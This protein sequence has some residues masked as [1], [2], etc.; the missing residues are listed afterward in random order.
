[1][2]IYSINNKLNQ[3]QQNQAAAQAKPEKPAPPAPQTPPE[4]A[5]F[6]AKLGLS[7]TNSKEGDMA[8]I[9]AKLAE[10]EATAKT[11]SQKQ[12]LENLKRELGNV[13]GSIQPPQGPPPP[14]AADFTGADQ[15]AALNKH[16]ML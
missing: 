11:D 5:A 1:M 10:L 7:P 6:M 9:E 3:Y 8:A 4:I 16:F 13:L 14:P 15:L 2:Q 12:N